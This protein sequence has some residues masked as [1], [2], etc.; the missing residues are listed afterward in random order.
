MESDTLVQP[1]LRGL[2]DRQI[3]SFQH[4]VKGDGRSLPA[5]YSDTAGFLGLVFVV[6]LL[7]H[8]VDAGGEIVDLELAVAVG[9]NSFVDALADDGKGNAGNLAILRGLDDLCAAKADFQL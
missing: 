5:D 8:G 7:R 3:T 9:L 2:V 4:I 1:V 6:G